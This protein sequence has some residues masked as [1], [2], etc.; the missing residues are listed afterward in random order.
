MVECFVV[1]CDHEYD[2]R[3]CMLVVDAELY[4]EQRRKRFHDHHCEGHELHVCPFKYAWKV[5][6][7]ELFP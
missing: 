4:A 3:V 6:R 5:V 7:A 1:V 2:Y